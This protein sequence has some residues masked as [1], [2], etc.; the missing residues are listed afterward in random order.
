MV[1]I[2]WRSVFPILFAAETLACDSKLRYWAYHDTLQYPKDNIVNP[3][4]SPRRLSQV[5]VYVTHM[6]TV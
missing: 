4:P 6:R 5:D 1:L 2:V 3:S